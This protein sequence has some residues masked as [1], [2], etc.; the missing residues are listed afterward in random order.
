MWSGKAFF[1]RWCFSKDLNEDVEPSRKT[2]QKN[3]VSTGDG[4]DK[5]I[6]TGKTSAFEFQTVRINTGIFE[7]V[8]I[9]V[10]PR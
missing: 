7:S 8:L 2:F 5:R 3:I 1:S 9:Q 4:G 6:D 10:L